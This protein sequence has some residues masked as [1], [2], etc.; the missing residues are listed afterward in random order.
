MCCLVLWFAVPVGTAGTR[1][2]KS[3]PRRIDGYSREGG[4]VEGGGP[5][6][7]MGDGGEESLFRMARI[8]PRGSIKRVNMRS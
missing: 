6:A 5:E 7:F 4:T 8:K 1:A 3:A 2:F